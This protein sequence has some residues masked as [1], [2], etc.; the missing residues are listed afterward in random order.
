MVELIMAL[1]LNMQSKVDQDACEAAWKATSKQSVY[2]QEY[3]KKEKRILKN[4]EKAV[5][6]MT[7]DEVWLITYG[8]YKMFVEKKYEIKTKGFISDY[9]K[10]SVDK[11]KYM[12]TIGWDLD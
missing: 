5:I 8:G 10:I 7:G 1:C 2:V 4:T 6:N 3:K 12:I 9:T 11:D